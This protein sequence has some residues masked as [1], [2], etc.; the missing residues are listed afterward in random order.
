MTLTTSS[1]VHED[2]RLTL[3]QRDAENAHCLLLG[4]LIKVNQ[5]H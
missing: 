5:V 1:N 4:Y 2:P 3:R